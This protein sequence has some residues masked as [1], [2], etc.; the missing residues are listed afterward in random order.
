MSSEYLVGSLILGIFAY[1]FISHLRAQ[2]M[3]A[4]AHNFPYPT[5]HFGDSGIFDDLIGAC[6]L[7]IGSINEP[8]NA[9]LIHGTYE[10]WTTFAHDPDYGYSA[11]FGGMIP[12]DDINPANGLP[13]IGDSGI[14]IHGN[15][16]GFSFND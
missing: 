3:A 11:D 1:C 9:P 2:S 12:I 7:S 6:P 15:P 8:F 10:E 13:M 14:D 16:Y 5:E 4:P